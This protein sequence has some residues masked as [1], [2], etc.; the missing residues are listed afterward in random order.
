MPSRS[1]SLH[2]LLPSH[3]RSVTAT[4]TVIVATSSFVFYY[5]YRILYD[6]ALS[7]GFVL[8][9][10]RMLPAF[11]VRAFG[12]R[13]CGVGMD[14][15]SG[16]R[17]R[18]PPYQK[19]W[20]HRVAHLAGLALEAYWSTT[21]LEATYM[22]WLP[23]IP[24]DGCFSSVTHVNAWKLRRLGCGAVAQLLSSLELNGISECNWNAHAGEEVKAR[25][26]GGE[27]F[28]SCIASM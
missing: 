15:A 27:R 6:L 2:R 12:F 25:R 18:V 1:C 20:A 21:T 22:T 8:H 17:A 13:L 28:R 26:A 7:G 3:F 4:A 9:L 11:R 24:S 5:G 14:A 16:G 23:T 19:L 10:A